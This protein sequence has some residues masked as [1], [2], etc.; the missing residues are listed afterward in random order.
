[1]LQYGEL[2]NVV[3]QA[4]ACRASSLNLP[5]PPFLRDQWHKRGRVAVIMC[6][7]VLRFNGEAK[8]SMVQDVVCHLLDAVVFQF[9]QYKR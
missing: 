4:A 9:A 8:V 6:G 1:V 7:L 3:Q 5:C 2:A